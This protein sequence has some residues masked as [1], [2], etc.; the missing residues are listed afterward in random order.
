MST[1]S[2]SI[3]ILSINLEGMR[4]WVV[5]LGLSGS[6]LALDTGVPKMSEKV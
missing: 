1:A 5:C 2:L 3:S 6:E 4:I